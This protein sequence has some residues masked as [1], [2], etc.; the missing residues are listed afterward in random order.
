MQTFYNREFYV[1]WGVWPGLI[2]KSYINVL[3]YTCSPAR[4]SCLNCWNLKRRSIFA[5]VYRVIFEKAKS[6]R[7]TSLSVHFKYCNVW[8]VQFWGSSF[9]STTKYLRNARTDTTAFA[10]PE[11]GYPIWMYCEAAIIF[12]N[13]FAIM[14][15][16]MYVIHGTNSVA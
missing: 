5:S 14:K 1:F 4:L 10:V 16:S 11:D 7:S 3:G 9:H 6:F 12:R 15:V 8:H 13:E 2:I